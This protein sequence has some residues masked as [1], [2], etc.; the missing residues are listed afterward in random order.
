MKKSNPEILRYRNNKFGFN[1][2][3]IAIIL[4][5]IAFIFVYD[6]LTFTPKFNT[7]LDIVINII[8]LLFVFLASEKV[9]TYKVMWG[10]IIIG[11]GLV[12]LVR[13][14]TYLYSP[15]SGEDLVNN[16]KESSF[17]ISLVSY[18]LVAVSLTLGGIVTI[19]RGNR[20][21]EFL[22]SIEKED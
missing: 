3:I 12:N 18:C 16:I 15:F 11:I 2:C 20:L 8:F 19:L 17:I 10:Y 1:A 4:Q 6:S 22:K 5:C 9:K 14:Y 21:N 13:I 7:G